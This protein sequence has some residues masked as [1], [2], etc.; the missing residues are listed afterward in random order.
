MCIVGWSARS[1]YRPNIGWLIWA[2]GGRF[3]S[4]TTTITLLLLLSRHIRFISHFLSIYI[5]AVESSYSYQLSTLF[6]HRYIQRDSHRLCDPFSQI[7]MCKFATT[8]LVHSRAQQ[9][10]MP[11]EY[12]VCQGKGINFLAEYILVVLVFKYGYLNFQRYTHTYLFF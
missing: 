7:D 6:Y 10:C 9:D 2:T 8:L 12:F 1:S 4:T 5:Y 3:Y 11:Y